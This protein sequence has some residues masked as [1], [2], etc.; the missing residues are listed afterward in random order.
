MRE[1]LLAHDQ[2][3]HFAADDL[4]HWVRGIGLAG[5]GRLGLLP[6]GGL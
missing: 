5:G 2:R 1:G 3:A 6:G 4:T